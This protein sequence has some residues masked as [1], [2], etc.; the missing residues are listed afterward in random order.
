M[1]DG[2]C[3][4]GSVWEAAMGIAHYNATNVITIVDRNQCMIDGR[5][6]D[7]MQLEPFVNKWE[8]F[9]FH[10]KNIDGHDFKQL[11]EAIQF[12]HDSSDKPTCIVANTFKGNGIKFMQD[13]YKYHYAGLDA[14]KVT[15]CKKDLDQYYAERIS[16][17]S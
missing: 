9:G 7:I 6:E 14:N 16:R 15:E 2:E 8:A 3:N 5:T 11:A 13:N 17:R 4:E 1:G 10:V 12:A